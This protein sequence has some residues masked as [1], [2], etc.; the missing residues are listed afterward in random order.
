MRIGHQAVA[1]ATAFLLVACGGGGGLNP[2]TSIPTSTTSGN[3]SN[4][5]TPVPP[6][7]TIGAPQAPT[8]DVAQPVAA[9]NV[10][11]AT[12]SSIPIGTSF[13]LLHSSLDFDP[14]HVSGA[15]DFSND[16]LIYQG[17][18]TYE[19]TI[20]GLNVDLTFGPN[21]TTKTTSTGATVSLAMGIGAYSVAGIWTYLDANSGVE[22]LFVSGF[23]TPAA[24]LPIEGTATYNGS[25]QAVGIVH[26]IS[27][28][29]FRSG[30][31]SGNAALTADF[32]NNKLTGLLSNFTLLDENKNTSPWGTVN[33]SGTLNLGKITGTTSVASMP[34]GAFALA[35]SATGF[36]SGELYGPGATE[37]GA[38]WSLSDGTNAVLGT[39][40]AVGGPTPPPPLATPPA[41][42]QDFMDFYESSSVTVA[43]SPGIAVPAAAGI[44]NNTASRLIAY[45]GGPSLNGSTISYEPNGAAFPLTQTVVQISSAGVTVDSAANSAGATLTIGSSGAN[46]SVTN[47]SLSL[48]TLGLNESIEATGQLGTAARG[49]VEGAFSVNVI[50]AVNFAALGNSY[51]SA[52]L[53]DASTA[54]GQVDIGFFVLG[55]EAPLSAIPSTGTATYSGTGTAMGYVFVPGRISQNPPVVNGD[56][57][58]TADFATGHITGMFTNMQTYDRSNPLQTNFIYSAPWN[59]VSVTADIAAG[60]SKFDGTVTAGAPPASSQYALKSGATGSI[61]GGLYGPN[62]EDVGAVWSLTNGDNT[63]TAVG[64]VAAVNPAAA[65]P[66][67]T[68]PQPETPPNVVQQFMST[69]LLAPNVTAAPPTIAAPPPPSAGQN[70]APSQVASAGGPTLN[71]NSSSGGPN[72]TFPVTESVVRIS[73]SGLSADATATTGGATISVLGVGSSYPSMN[74]TIPAVGITAYVQLGSLASPTSG[75]STG[76]YSASMAVASL[77]Y[78]SFGIWAAANSDGTSP[79]AVGAFALGFETPAAAIPASGTAN[80]SGTGNVIGN[81]YVAGKIGGTPAIVN[82][83]AS[84]MANFGT[85][86]INGALTNMV[87]HD[88]ANPSQPANVYAFPWND[89]SV[90]ASIAA[91]T[92]KFSGST[93]AASQPV[94]PY[95]LKSTATGSINGGFYGPN[96]ENIGAVWTLSNGDGTGSALGVI[97]ATKQ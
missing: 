24:S 35:S 14:G 5:G 28:G 92:A 45:A 64:V 58:L 62:A 23:Q 59:N 51:T 53:W 63:G 15:I 71:G 20:P 97:G 13:G 30:A 17:P 16:A 31:I 76:V 77:S 46:S 9:N 93:A 87:V 54:S 33:V 95:A 47:F 40:T 34:A 21:D 74:L 56:A 29:L 57:S 22:T 89:V 96:A 7:F 32:P 78:T 38:V 68:L 18:G 67:I 48:P 3:N 37:I 50:G 52:G 27:N 94:S 19:L 72:L 90:S 8:L 80:Y 1:C 61:N 82:G 12:A 10:T 85:G 26:T 69:P 73:S 25:G 75:S 79:F 65:T 44:G 36:F 49:G 4:A 41:V 55:Y 11:F 39:V 66:P 43:S 6:G 60:T 84:L 83:D 91:G 2:A 86:Q 42:V 81:V 88:H 70:P